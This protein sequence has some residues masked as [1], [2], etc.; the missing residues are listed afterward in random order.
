MTTLKK[1]QMPQKIQNTGPAVFTRNSPGP[2]LSGY[3]SIYSEPAV[4]NRK[5]VI[6]NKSKTVRTRE[7][8]GSEREKPFIE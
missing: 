7:V 4:I 6:V 3:I 2:G 8:F 1:S 5:L